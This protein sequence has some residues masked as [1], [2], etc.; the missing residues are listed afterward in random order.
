MSSEW[1]DGKTFAFSIFDDTDRASL[2]NNRAV[3]G[4]LAD[5]G[6]RTTKSVWICDGREPP[7]IPGAT[8]DDPEYVRFLLELQESGFEIA[9]HNATWETSERYETIRGLDRFRSLFGHDPISAANHASN[10]EGIYWGADRVSGWQRK[11]W[12]KLEPAARFAGHEEES[13]LF[14]GDV[15]R[16]RIR[17]VR[18]F[19]FRDINTLRKCP[20]M[21]Y[22]DPERPWVRRWFSGSCGSD[23]EEF[24]R[25]LMPGNLDRLEAEGGACIVYTHFGK[26]FH[27]DGRLDSVFRERVSDLASRGGWFVPVSELLDH[28]ENTREA[29]PEL[30]PS[31][32]R[33]LEIR[34]LADRVLQSLSR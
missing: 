21:P 34:W 13:P 4:F 31:S 29:S 6:L 5:A 22:H 23:I 14:W 26:G 20:E 18:N 9:W 17:Y 10:R 1:P 16:E 25:L 2:E 30:S 19:C 12:K 28:I 11:L 15:C 7:R 3:Y 33:A 32:R 27:E 8:C 24:N